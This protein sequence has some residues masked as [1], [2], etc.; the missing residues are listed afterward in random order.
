MPFVREEFIWRDACPS[1]HYKGPLLEVE[2]KKG[3]LALF[4]LRAFTEQQKKDYPLL[5]P[6]YVTGVLKITP[7]KK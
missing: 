3:T 6:F 4:A 2:L 5:V 7:L 1:V